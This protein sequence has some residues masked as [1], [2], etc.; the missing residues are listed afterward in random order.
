MNIMPA[1]YDLLERI[2]EGFQRTGIPLIG[3]ENGQ[4][5]PRSAADDVGI[6]Y[7]VPLIARWCGVG[8]DAALELFYFGIVGPAVLAGATACFFITKH[9]GVRLYALAGL[10]VLA[11]LTRFVGDVYIALAAVT[12]GILPWYIWFLKR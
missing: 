2:L 7:F 6:Y 1:R 10:L 11:A 9:F 3:W 4:W 5:V 8:L 12:V